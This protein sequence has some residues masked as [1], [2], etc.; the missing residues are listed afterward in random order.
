M[1]TW[2]SLTGLVAQ[3]PFC[4]GG[5]FGGQ[6]H[7]G[8]ERQVTRAGTALCSAAQ[9]SILAPRFYSMRFII[10]LAVL[11]LANP[12][13]RA[14]LYAQSALTSLRASHSIVA[15]GSDVRAL[16]LQNLGVGT[17]RIL[18]VMVE[19]QADADSRTTG[20]GQFGGLPYL[21]AAGD[22]VIDPLPHDRAYFQRKLDFLRNYFET[23]SDG[24]TRITYAVPERV[25]RVS[26]VMSE[27]S[28]RRGEG[29]ERLAE[30]IRE[31][32]TL[33]DAQSPEL[34]VSQFDCFI[35]FHA[36]VGRDID[37]VALGGADPTPFD[38]P[39]L[40][41]NLGSFRR[42]FGAEFNGFAMRGGARITN[43]SLLPA[44]ETREI[45]AIGGTALLELSTNGL[46]CASFASFL[47]VPDLFNTVNGRSGIGRF[48]LL[49]G[50]GFFNYNG[51]LPPE[52]SAWERL[53]LGWA[54]P[55]EARAPAQTLRLL[56]QGLHQNSDSVIYRVPIS[57]REYF[58]LENRQR[59][60]RGQGVTLTMIRR[61]TPTLL[62]FTRDE[63]G[64]SFGDISRLNG[65][66][67]ACNNYEWTLPGATV[68]NRRFDGGVLIWRINE[69]LIAERRDSNRINAVEP[70]A[71]F[72]LEA[73]GSQD[74]GQNYGIQD[75]GNGTQS[76]VV[77]DA[78]FQGNI[79]PF[80]RN[81][82]DDNTFPNTRAARGAPTQIRFSAFSL[83]APIMT[84]QVQRGSAFLRPLQGFPLQL[85]GD[86]DRRA[87]P[88]VSDTLVIVQNARGEAFMNAMR[89]ESFASQLKPA[90]NSSV[91]LGASGDTLIAFIR[92]TSQTLRRRFGARITTLSLERAGAT[93][94]PTY[95]IG[96]ASGVVFRGAISPAGIS[97]A[98]SL[99]V[100]SR[101]IV[102]ATET[103]QVA[104]DRAQFGSTR[105]TFDGA[106][107]T[108]AAATG[109]AR[110]VIGAAILQDKTLLLLRE[111]GETLRI[112]VPCKNPILSSPAFA[113][114]E[115]RGEVATIIA[116]DDKIFAYNP[117]G[118]LIT[119]FP[120]QVFS[121][122]PLACS[123]VIADLDG[124]TFEDLIIHA[125]DGRLAGYNRLGQTLFATAIAQGTETTPSVAWLSGAA[126][127]HLYS[128]DRA[129]LLQ[130]FE[131][132]ASSANVA[133]SS[134]YADAQNSNAFQPQRAPNWQRVT[135][136]E[137]FP[138]KS[139]YNYPNPA[140]E[141]TRFRFYLRD[142]ARVTIKVFSLT[143]EKIWEQTVEGRGG[144]DNEVVWNLSNV[145]SGVYYGV[146]T[147]E[148]R[149]SESV[150]LKIAVVK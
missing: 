53:I 34:D 49:D 79:A 57:S 39:S 52:P 33:V 113:D 110:G 27:Y 93:A 54:R 59:D 107:A 130:G 26:K 98:E 100:S 11:F 95:R 30:L 121:E 109:F 55:I 129:G 61:G 118:A 18:A 56:A 14:P 1:T 91:V 28:P 83:P 71:V 32:W 89:L 125:P 9:V 74:I 72:L 103:I 66:I 78:F 8:L 149:E 85:S 143:G 87:S 84:A 29:N 94:N 44:T 117:N 86:F 90:A 120:I 92:A 132:L 6:G 135:I 136:N 142:D 58:L 37:L 47:G 42:V 105:W 102:S 97:V 76:G 15:E 16:P 68:N 41:F 148:Q 137:F 73:D 150:R 80:Y 104:E 96:T 67:V 112:A 38:L 106:P 134:L 128:I 101:P 141:E 75:A 140:R 3:A 24:K 5:L 114:L 7:F 81:Q 145:Q 122:K 12:L 50:E 147:P 43:T 88:T 133:W 25:Y 99:Q 111:G 45:A 70:R 108:A 116:A 115:H 124:D 144:T 62:T 48:G 82:I 127:L 146:I 20:T 69:D 19:F 35:I 17:F 138:A 23:C 31:V 46:L 2:K 63:A 60:A 64:F 139:A 36:G 126:R 123:P 21:V 51:A 77:F 10:F 65:Q 119:N 22:T 13:L 4:F 131:L 40:T